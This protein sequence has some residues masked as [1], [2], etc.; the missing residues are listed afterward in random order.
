MFNAPSQERWKV[1]QNPSTTWP[2]VIH[3]SLKRL[4]SWLAPI[5]IRA[6]GVIPQISSPC[7]NVSNAFWDCQLHHE[8]R[9]RLELYLNIAQHT[10][11]SSEL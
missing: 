3:G 10:K 5:K 9:W 2:R 1:I 6:D 8:G 11:E 4:V 7:R